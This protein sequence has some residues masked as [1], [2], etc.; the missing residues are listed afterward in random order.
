MRIST[1]KI[2]RRLYPL[3]IVFAVLVLFMPR[4]AKFSYDYRKGSPWPYETLVSEFDFPILKTEEQLMEEHEKADGGT[5][6][7]YRYSEEVVNNTAKSVRGLDLGKYA[8]L[9]SSIASSMDDIYA[10]GVISDT[11]EKLDRGYG[12]LSN[13]VIYIQRNKRA[14]QYPRSEVYKVSDA[15]EKLLSDVSRAYPDVNVDSLFRHAKVYDLIVPN[16]AFDRTMTE[17]SHAESAAYVSPTSGIVRAEQK[18]VTKGEIVTPEIAQILDSY[19]A[20][21]NKVFGYEGSWVLLL[22]GN[23]LI[24]LALVV[25]LYFCIFFTNR[26]IFGKPGR[27]FYLLTVFTLTA[28]ASFLMERIAP[29]RV[30]LMPFAIVILYLQAFFPKRVVLPVYMVSLLPLL[31]FSGNGVELF[32]MFLCAGIVSMNTFKYFNRGWLQ[33]VNA[34]VIFG[35]E[36][37]V[38]TGFRLIDAGDSLVWLNVLFLFIG[39]MLTVALYPVVY[40][41]ERVFNLVSTT[42]LVELTDTNNKLLR[43]LN[44]KAPGTFQHSLQVMNMADEAGHSVHANVPL[45]RAAALYHDLG[46]MRNPLCFIENSSRTPGSPNYHEGKSPRESARDIIAH[47]QDGLEIAKANNLPTEVSDF[48]LTHHGTS[49]TASFYNQYLNEGGDP[50][51]VEDFYYKGRK[52]RTK[53]E[54]ILMICDSVEAASRTL[55][56]YTPASFDKFVE[57]MVAAKEKSGQF[58]HAEITIREMNI[59]KATL[60]TYLQ[61]LYHERIEYTQREENPEENE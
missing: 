29:S 58:E 44:A 6:P 5:V 13:E 42:R 23:I 3:A 25:I 40:L 61:Q 43:E 9:R 50:N 36:A 17:L 20:E 26:E 38:F 2:P 57:D 33:F 35:V 49:F 37:V 8:R 10:K 59:V 14:S 24:A 48:I 55:K 34:L 46:K 53:E 32:F 45:L 1:P 39:S 56:E 28:V 18:I 52:P 41:F 51:D 21:Y 19:K 27:Y 7:Y 16:L 12:T 60:K 4:T 30:Y 54:V 11:K 22:L 15:R 47:V 31:I